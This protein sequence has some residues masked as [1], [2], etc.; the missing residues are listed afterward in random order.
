VGASKKEAWVCWRERDGGSSV[1]LF[2]CVRI[3]Q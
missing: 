2:A 1:T 3:A